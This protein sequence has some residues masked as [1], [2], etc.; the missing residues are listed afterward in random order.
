MY[1]IHYTFKNFESWNSE[2]EKALENNDIPRKYLSS[3][4]KI[5]IY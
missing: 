5:Q 4:S 3:F 2:L 1:F